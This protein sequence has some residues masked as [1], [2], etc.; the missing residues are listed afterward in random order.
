MADLMQR[1]Q[2]CGHPFYLENY[3]A[4]YSA[5]KTKYPEIELIAN[6]NLDGKAPTEIWDWCV[7]TLVCVCVC[8]GLCCIQPPR[9]GG[10]GGGGRRGC[11]GKLSHP[12]KIL[13]LPVWRLLLPDGISLYG[14]L[15]AE[16]FWCCCLCS[17][18]PLS[19][20]VAWSPCAAARWY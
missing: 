10:G 1:L 12:L 17:S 18:G 15:Q 11:W 20:F 16:C 4:Y 8:C 7:C 3:A 13:I 19:L 6:C 9:G 5:L 2:D 14:G